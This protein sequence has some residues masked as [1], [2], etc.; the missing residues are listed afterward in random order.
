M[1]CATVTILYP[2]GSDINFDMSYYLSSHMPMLL[3]SWKSYGLT[4]YTVS[5]PAEG[6]YVC[7]CYLNF[8]SFEGF[9]KA[10]EG[11]ERKAIREDVQNY[12]NSKV[13]LVPAEVV[14]SV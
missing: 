9:K 12:T 3:K 10:S 13:V 5:K 11:P 7:I 6:P 8:S 14:G 4:N 1:S 2:S